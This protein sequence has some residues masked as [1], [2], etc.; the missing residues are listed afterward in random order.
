M[1]TLITGAPG[2]GKTAALVSLLSGM[3]P[4]RV[5]YCDGI[6]DLTVA[7]QVLDNPNDWMASVPDGSAIVIDEVQRIWRPAG[8][9]AKVPAAIEALETHR[10]HG[11]DFFLVTQ[12]PNLVHSNVRRLVGRHIHL[13]D[14]GLLGRWWYE[15]PESTDPGRFRDAPIKKSYKLPKAAFSLYKS[16]SLHIKPIRS[17]P[18]IVFV[19]AAAVLA[20]AVLGWFAYRSIS[21]KGASVVPVLPAPVGVGVP[22]APQSLPLLPRSSVE[23][24]AVMSWPRYVSVAPK[25]MREPYADMAIQYEGGYTM[26]TAIYAVFGLLVQG[27]RVATVSLSSLLQSGYTWTT[28]GACAGVLRFGELERLVTCASPSVASPVDRL[29]APLPP[30]SPPGVAVASAL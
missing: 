30:T 18:N 2:A 27:Q 11:L 14:V 9:G 19:L 10:H 20:F 22:T 28:L 15:W 29:A 16:A 3:A 25:V 5:I 21:S 13:R 8:S 24:P 23:E 26:G 17:M 7:H 4:G 6:P 12:H 1:I